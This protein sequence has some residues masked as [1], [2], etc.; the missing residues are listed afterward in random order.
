MHAKVVPIDICGDGHG[1]K[2][3]NEKL[4]NFLVMELLQDLLPEREV[5]GHGAWLV[6]PAEHDHV[7]RVV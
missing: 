5:L 3:A 1:F 4:V 2:Q 7:A 6:I